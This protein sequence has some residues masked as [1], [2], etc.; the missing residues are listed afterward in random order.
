MRCQEQRGWPFRTEVS[1]SVHF[2]IDPMKEKCASTLLTFHVPITTTRFVTPKS[3]ILHTC[4]D[5]AS[6]H[7]VTTQHLVHVRGRHVDSFGHNATPRTFVA[8]T[9]RFT[10]SQLNIWYM[11]VSESSN[12]K[13]SERTRGAGHKVGS[14]FAP[15]CPNLTIFP[16]D[17]M[18]E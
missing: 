16:I 7:E 10:S 6:V 15:K 1:E 9:S 4:V 2:L 18:K 17:P 12:C 3:V 14:H 8:T 13:V 5:D 11:C